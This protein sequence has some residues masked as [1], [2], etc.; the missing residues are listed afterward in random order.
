MEDVS[1]L[2]I[3]ILLFKD[4][5]RISNEIRVGK[6]TRY[7]KLLF[8]FFSSSLITKHEKYINQEITLKDTQIYI[9]SFNNSSQSLKSSKI[10]VF[11]KILL[12]LSKTVQSYV[13]SELYR[14]S[15]HFH[16]FTSYL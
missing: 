5:F 1:K 8:S 14:Y 16:V 4:F 2:D 7:G 3:I 13:N 15:K 9:N 11:Y 10:L 6:Y 12:T